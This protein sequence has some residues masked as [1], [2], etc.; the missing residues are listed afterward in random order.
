[1]SLRSKQSGNELEGSMEE[2]LEDTIPVPV[3]MQ[4]EIDTDT[5][6]SEG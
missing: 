1:M 3:S 6:D 4:E 2:M 5:D